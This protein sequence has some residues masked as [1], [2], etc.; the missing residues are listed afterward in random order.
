MTSET[1]MLAR[2][3]SVTPCICKNLVLAFNP[4]RVAYEHQYRIRGQDVGKLM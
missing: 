2:G 3:F 1:S 4:Y